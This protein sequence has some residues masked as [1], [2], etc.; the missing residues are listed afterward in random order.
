MAFYCYL[1]KSGCSHLLMKVN[2]K[3][4]MSKSLFYKIRYCIANSSGSCLGWTLMMWIWYFIE[5]VSLLNNLIR[6]CLR[7]KGYAAYPNLL[8]TER[9]CCYCCCSYLRLLTGSLCM[10]RNLSTRFAYNYMKKKSELRMP[11]SNYMQKK[12]GYI[13]FMELSMLNLT[14]IYKNLCRASHY[15]GS[16]LVMRKMSFFVC[17]LV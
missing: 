2:E 10:R 7:L 9:L 12:N 14:Y 6:S 16:Q 17:R 11:I 13:Y 15:S 1:Q 4:C 5:V 3:W 8:G